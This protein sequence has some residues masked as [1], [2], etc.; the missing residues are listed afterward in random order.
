MAPK[1]SPFLRWSEPVPR[2]HAH[3]KLL[4][5]IPETKVR[6]ACSW[7][8]LKVVRLIRPCVLL[9]LLLPR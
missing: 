8:P 6:T 2:E 5:A 3:S 1:D 7:T 4:A 9:L